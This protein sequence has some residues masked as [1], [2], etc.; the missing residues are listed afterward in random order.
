MSCYLWEQ[1]AHAI[2]LSTSLVLCT[3]VHVFGAQQQ[4]IKYCFLKLVQAGTCQAWNIIAF[5]IWCDLSTNGQVM[6]SLWLFHLMHI[7]DIPD[8]LLSCNVNAVFYYVLIL[9]FIQDLELSSLNIVQGTTCNCAWYAA[10]LITELSIQLYISL[11]IY[12]CVCVCVCLCMCVYIYIYVCMYVYTHIYIY[13][14]ISQ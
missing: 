5:M 3:H 4:V 12:V 8:C 13:I 14:Y 1:C 7:S 9:D 11:Y 2:V 6:F 10:Y